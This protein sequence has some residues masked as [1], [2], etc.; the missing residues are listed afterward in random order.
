MLATIQ[1]ML[2]AFV[3]DKDATLYTAKTMEQAW[4]LNM[5]KMFPTIDNSYKKRV[6][7]ENWSVLERDLAKDM[8]A[9]EDLLRKMRK[10]LW[11]LQS[12]FPGVKDF[13]K[14]FPYPQFVCTADDRDTT[15]QQF[16]RDGLQ[17]KGICCG[18]DPGVQNKPEQTGLIRML[19]EFDIHPTEA[20]IVGDSEC[21]MQFKT[22]AGLGLAIFI[23][24]QGIKPVPKEADFV[25]RSVTDIPTLFPHLPHATSIQRLY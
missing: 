23:D 22:A 20:C 13:L 15:I 1:R 10:D 24:V 2:R 21:D 11:I 9:N 5:K 6:K 18:D 8:S 25:V 12:P 19:D 14:D 17:F 4:F 16:K 7:W 3:F